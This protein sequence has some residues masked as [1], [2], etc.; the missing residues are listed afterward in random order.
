[1]S[2]GFDKTVL[3]RCLL[4]QHAHLGHSLQTGIFLEEEQESTA[5]FQQLVNF[6]P[7]LQ[8]V[9]ASRGAHVHG[10][11]VCSDDVLAYRVAGQ[12]ELFYRASFFVRLQCSDHRAGC[13][14][15]GHVCDPVP[16]AAWGTRATL[17]RSTG[18][19]QLFKLEWTVASCTWSALNNGDMVVLRQPW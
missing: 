6:A 18:A 15:V 5:M 11:P 3:E 4:V 1:M 12:P 19:L 7:L 10:L 9:T 13:Y 16:S 8:R 14:G 17:L 2:K